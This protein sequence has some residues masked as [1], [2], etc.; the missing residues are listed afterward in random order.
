[1]YDW[2]MI[3]KKKEQLDKARP[4]RKILLKA[5]KKKSLWNGPFTPMP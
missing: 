3:D 2:K 4:F 1:M 5:C